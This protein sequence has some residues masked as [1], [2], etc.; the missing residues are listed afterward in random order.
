MPLPNGIVPHLCALSLALAEAIAYGRQATSE[1]Q[2]R[3]SPTA[4]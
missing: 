4:E 3:C 1:E 2:R